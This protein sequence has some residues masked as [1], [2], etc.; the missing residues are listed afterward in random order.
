L[1]LAGP[2]LWAYLATETSNLAYNPHWPP[3]SA[4]QVVSVGTVAL[5]ELQTSSAYMKIGDFPDEP[6]P[7][8]V[9]NPSKK[10]NQKIF[11]TFWAIQ[12]GK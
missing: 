4:H 11:H 9:L 5:Q 7:P 6:I 2:A 12:V 10:P 1:P 8:E 3:P